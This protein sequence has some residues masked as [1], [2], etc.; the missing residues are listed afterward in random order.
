MV[1]NS[2]ISTRTQGEVSI[3]VSTQLSYKTFQTI[4]GLPIR[5]PHD[6]QIVNISDLYTTRHGRY[7]KRVQEIVAKRLARGGITCSPQEFFPG[8]EEQE[9]TIQRM[10]DDLRSKWKQN[11][12]GYRPSD[13]AI[14]Y[15]RPD[16]IRQLGGQSKSTHTYSYSGFDQLVH[17]SSGL[18]R[19]FLDAAARMFDEQRGRLSGRPLTITPS[20]QDAIIRIGAD[21][22][23]TSEFD[24]MAGDAEISGRRESEAKFDDMQLR[25]ARLRNIISALGGAFYLKLISDEAERRVFS[26]AMSGVPDRDVVNVL[27]IGV[28]YSYFHRSTIGNKDGTGR[29]ELYVLTRR[30]APYFKLDPS[31]FAGYLWVTSEAMRRAMVD[32]DATI[33]KARSRG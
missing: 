28:R 10:A 26:V 11:P 17:I 24:Q 15:A 18:I 25:M 16:Y 5:S 32:P 7:R 20:V 1:L 27:E 23:M 9:R 33:R 29:T 14:R 30:L 3:K 2:W 6:F 21:E 22:L 31:S 8:D 19:Y 12:R 13:D 4:S